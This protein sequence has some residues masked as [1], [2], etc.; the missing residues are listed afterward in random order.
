MQQYLPLAVLKLKGVD[1]NEVI[2]FEIV[3]TVLTACGIE[4]PQAL[5]EQL[6]SYIRVATVLTACGIET[7]QNMVNPYQTYLVATVLTACGIETGF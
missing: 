3:A 4:T 7:L 2:F 1:H 6:H 5:G